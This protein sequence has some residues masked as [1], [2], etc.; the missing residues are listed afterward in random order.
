MSF[1]TMI[2][3]FIK[4]R[5]VLIILFNTLLISSMN[6]QSD[7]LHIIKYG[8][9]FR[10]GPIWF[11]V[12]DVIS[13]LL[14]LL[15]LKNDMNDLSLFI[16]VRV[17]FDQFKKKAYTIYIM[18]IFILAVISHWMIFKNLFSYLVIVEAFIYYG[19]IKLVQQENQ[20]LQKNNQHILLLYLLGAKYFLTIFLTM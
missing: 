7:I 18:L 1:K 10:M 3:K 13:K 12:V 2:L 9:V 4:K 5:Y 20:S 16:S 11:S 15:A 19:L 14:L 8:I 6:Y 17:D